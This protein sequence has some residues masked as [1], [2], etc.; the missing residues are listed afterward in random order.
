MKGQYWVCYDDTNMAEQAPLMADGTSTADQVPNGYFI[1]C[2]L[3][4]PHG[5]ETSAYF[6]AGV[7]SDFPGYLQDGDH[8]ASYPDFAAALAAIAAHQASH[9]PS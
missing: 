3:H 6:L 8:Q 4:G 5:A 7:N 1:E 9:T 2:H